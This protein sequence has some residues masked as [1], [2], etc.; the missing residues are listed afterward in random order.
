MPEPEINTDGNFK[1][2]L[3]YDY[4]R[5]EEVFARQDIILYGKEEISGKNCNVNDCGKPALFK[6]N[7]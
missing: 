2:T 5:N 4:G 3:L 6:C 1:E 7:R